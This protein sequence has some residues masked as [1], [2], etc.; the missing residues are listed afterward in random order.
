M[1]KCSTF[2][3]SLLIAAGFTASAAYQTAGNYSVYTF[4]SL[5]QIDGSGVTKD[6]DDF[7]VASDIEIAATDTLRLLNGETVKLGNN[8]MITFY[9]YADFTPSE[10]ATITRNAESDVPRGF[11]IFEADACGQFENVNFLYA[12]LRTFGNTKGITVRECSFV[13]TNTAMTSTG[14]IS[15]G[16][17]N[18]ENIIEDCVFIQTESGAIGGS[19][20]GF[21]GVTVKGCT[22]HQCNTGNSNRPVINLT[23]GGDNEVVIENNTIYGGKFTMVGGIGVSNMLGLSA[24]NV[25]K[26]TGNYVQDCRYGFTSIGPMD[27]TLE[28]NTFINNRYETNAMNGG[29]A[30][31]LYD[32]YMQQKVLSLIHI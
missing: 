26:I 12:G 9:G 14:A 21:A 6:G 22:F 18:A 1:T 7:V 28:N 10:A 17:T 13:K 15:L 16:S 27:V 5:S 19:A 32:P 30:M 31:S 20:N 2:L 25:A 24:A 29:S 11:Y 3:A 4:E 8:V 23:I